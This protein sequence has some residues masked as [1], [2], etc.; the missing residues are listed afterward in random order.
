MSV[1]ETVRWLAT[2]LAQVREAGPTDRPV[3][4][5]ADLD[6]A[7]RRFRAPRL[8]DDLVRQVWELSVGTVALQRGDMA[9]FHMAF[10][11]PAEYLVLS[12][13]KRVSLVPDADSPVRFDSGQGIWTPLR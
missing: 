9:E 3:T 10:R 12:A 13:R 8:V 2:A 11:G 7:F 4:A 6:N 1:D 5:Q